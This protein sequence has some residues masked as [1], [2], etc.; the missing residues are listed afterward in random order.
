[1]NSKSAIRNPRSAIGPD[2]RSAIGPG[3]R[4]AIIAGAG[5]A[6]SSLAIRLATRGF[7]TTLI[8]RERFPREKLC[9]EFISPECLKHFEELGV[10]DELLDVGGD[11]IHET[12][13]FESGGRSVSVPND[14]FE[15]DSFAL[16]LSRSVMDN[17]L[18]E[19]A[20]AVGV[21]VIDGCSVTSVEKEN[22]M[23]RGVSARDHGG[24]VRELTGDVFVDATGRGQVLTKLTRT[25]KER[26]RPAFVG[27][28]AH[29]RE[30]DVPKGVCEIYSFPGGYAGLSNVEGDRTNLC[31]LLKSEVVRAAGS[32]ANELVDKVIKKNRRA[33]Q[34]LK[35]WQATGDWLA[36][37]VSSF[38]VTD[39]AP[40]D[41]L[42]TVG[43]AAAFIDPFT[44]S[45]M[46]MALQGASILS[47]SLIGTSNGI[48]AEY[49]SGY[50]ER[51]SKRLRVCWALRQIAFMPRL[52]TCVV[53]GLRVSSGA[54]RY[55]V[56]TTRR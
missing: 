20:R 42:F 22:G 4:S 41:N 21:N 55:L 44:G 37:S 5:P 24:T 14:W 6:G 26:T 7:E 1:M 48:S 56:R 54:R 10:L 23:V 33:R 13:F 35:Q 31:F 32:D 40:Y 43:D 11:R 30:A 45:G 3:P 19:R 29:L 34:T 25:N 17:A 2:P 18:L 49:C 36:V 9:G 46:L 53:A 38:G 47:D 50:K 28:K 27:F 51:F 12:S 15:K 16:S 39:P 52:A 8:E